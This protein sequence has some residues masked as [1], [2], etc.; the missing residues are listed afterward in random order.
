MSFIAELQQRKVLKTLLGYLVLCWLILQITDVI[1]PILD[2]P[3]WVAKLILLLLLSGLPL[4]GLFA[5]MFDL[6]A[7]GLVRE[8]STKPPTAQI[9][10]S[11]QHID[12]PLR[13]A[14]FSCFWLVVFGTF[15]AVG[16]AVT[17]YLHQSREIG[18][19]MEHLAH[20]LVHELE[21]ILT[22]EAVAIGAL[23][24]FF[25]PSQA[26]DLA[27]F[28]EHAEQ[29]LSEHPEMRAAE[30]VPRVN[31]IDAAE[32]QQTMQKHYPGFSIKG[33]DSSGHET[34]PS[35]QAVFFPVGFVIPKAGNAE[36]IGFDLSSNPDR[37]E[38]IYR[39]AI[40]GHPQLSRIITLV[41]SGEPGILLFNPVYSTSVLPVSEKA[42]LEQLNG[43]L[44]SVI[45]L[46][47]LMSL[48]VTSMP[49]GNWFEGRILSRDLRLSEAA[50]RLVFNN[51]QIRE[52]APS[53]RAEAILEDRFGVSWLFE[54]EPSRAMARSMYSQAHWWIGGTGLLVTFLTALLLDRL[55]RR[56]MKRQHRAHVAGLVYDHQDDSPVGPTAQSWPTAVAVKSL[57]PD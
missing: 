9:S 28:K 3:S 14:H 1:L 56:L 16:A 30:W 45:D 27:A 35:K 12:W 43:F 24:E 55:D 39:S 18:L 2:L 33:F 29:I 37:S 19:R 23:R 52:Y 51:D 53:Y 13:R 21:N 26:F 49:G 22:S 38:A 11:S 44:L 48:A 57:R 8:R 4:A 15:L 42:R 47:S 7:E 46:D 36:A 31:S 40:S 17:V 25:M 41:Q 32:F 50:P 6:R 54:I 20:D 10:S 5:W 34:A